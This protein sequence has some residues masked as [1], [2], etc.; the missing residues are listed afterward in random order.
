MS[1]N[2]ELLQNLGKEQDFFD[3]GVEVPER[4]IA[5]PEPLL[6]LKSPTLTM[7]AAQREEVA[8]L[9]QRVFL[10][11]GDKAARFVVFAG[12]EAGAGCSW[13]CSRAAEV[14]GSQ[15]AG[16]VCVGGGNLRFARVH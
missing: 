7:E 13:I 3:G 10:L 11:P 8:K 12:S 6:E 16:S 4:P 9:V 2:F 5:A 15:V 1:R 14:L